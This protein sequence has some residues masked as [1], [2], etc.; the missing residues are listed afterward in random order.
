[1]SRPRPTGDVK[2]LH[3]SAARHSCSTLIAHTIRTQD[4]NK[5]PITEHARMHEWVH[6]RVREKLR[7][8]E[9]IGVA[10]CDVPTVAADDVEVPQAPPRLR[11]HQLVRCH[12]IAYR[13]IALPWD[14]T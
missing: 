4:E 2:Q 5:T 13:I 11:Y 10:L 9:S 8:V 3:N 14:L 7:Q 12:F 6:E 1:M